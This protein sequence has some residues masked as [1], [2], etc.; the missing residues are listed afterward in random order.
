MLNFSEFFL[1]FYTTNRGIVNRFN[2]PFASCFKP[3][4]QSE[5]KCEAIDLKM[6]FNFNAHKTHFPNKGFALSLILKIRI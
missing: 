2:S 1:V 6:I 5:A 4:F 3:L